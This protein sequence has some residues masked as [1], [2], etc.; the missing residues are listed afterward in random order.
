MTC[1]HRLNGTTLR[2][3]SLLASSSAYPICLIGVRGSRPDAYQNVVCGTY[4]GAFTSV[5][6]HVRTY[7]DYVH[8][9]Y[10][11]Y[12]H[13]HCVMCFYVCPVSRLMAVCP[14]PH[15]PRVPYPTLPTY[16]HTCSMQPRT[17]S[18]S[19]RKADFTSYGHA[20][21]VSRTAFGKSEGGRPFIVGR[22]TARA[23]VGCLP[24]W[25]FD[26]WMHG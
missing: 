13:R 3:F 4:L 19:G 18:L 5:R 1:D 16:I 21:G 17:Q 9:C 20:R 8:S 15:S 10:A 25:M 7:V 26:V 24:V 23:C 22:C 11:M 2:A 14:L 12:A 6:T